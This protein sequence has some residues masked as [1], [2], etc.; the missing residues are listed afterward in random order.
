[1]RRSAR[2]S[3]RASSFLLGGGPPDLD[4]IRFTTTTIAPRARRPRHPDK[5][6]LAT[7]SRSAWTTRPA[8][9]QPLLGGAAAGGPTLGGGG[10]GGLGGGGACVG[11]VAVRSAAAPCVAS[12]DGGTISSATAQVS[13]VQRAAPSVMPRSS[14]IRFTS[15]PDTT[16]QGRPVGELSNSA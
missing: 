10:C 13:T 2:V 12:C 9:F 5:T 1:R 3:S 16:G 15:R 4:P 7:P 8:L 11:T 14:T 6:T